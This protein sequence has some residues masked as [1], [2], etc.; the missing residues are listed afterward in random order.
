[1]GEAE[2]GATLDFRG[3]HP[4]DSRGE[5]STVS[6]VQFQGIIRGAVQELQPGA[7]QELQPRQGSK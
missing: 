3:G 2:V 6:D 7:V 4:P 5:M 1:M